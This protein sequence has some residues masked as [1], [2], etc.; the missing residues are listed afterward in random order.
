[1]LLLLMVYNKCPIT[2]GN[3]VYLPSGYDSHSHGKIH[4]FLSS[5]NQLFLWAIYTM[6]M[7]NNQMVDGENHAMQPISS[8]NNLGL[9]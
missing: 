6:A 2:T 3:I 8:I 5:V 9:N 4:P 7:L 1:M